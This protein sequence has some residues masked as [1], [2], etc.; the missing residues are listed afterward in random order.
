[1]T[2]SALNHLAETVQYNCNVSDARHGADDSL[3]IYLMKMREYFRWERRLPFGAP[4]ERQQVGEWLQAR[5]ELWEQ[6]EHA[7]LLPI[8]IDEQCY[9]PFDAD[10]INRALAP[11]GLVYSGGLGTHGKPH[12][13]LGDLEQHRRHGDRSVFIVADEYARDLSAPPAMTLGQSIFVRRE[14]LRR[15]LWEKL[16]SWRWSRPDNA[17]GRAFACYDF[18][19]ALDASLDAMADREAHT[20]LL[21]EQGETLAGEQLGDAWGRLILDLA[22]TPAEIMA[23]A[24]RDHLADCLVTIPHLAAKA[25][26]ASIHFFVGQLTNMR[27]EIFPGL[28][29]AYASWRHDGGLEGFDEVAARGRAHW[30]SLA[31]AM[32]EI[33]REQGAA[34]DQAIRDL[35]QTRPL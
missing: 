17:L 5:E 10:A 13:V 32:L 1:M 29:D 31:Q 27:K 34:L 25:Q 30:L 20:L 11:Q 33:H 14:S 22:G 12:F 8:E 9:D 26:A 19:N 21:H 16:E 23:R 4:L 15:M 35:V 24:V 28:Q 18:D 6:L 2:H 3:C 7:D